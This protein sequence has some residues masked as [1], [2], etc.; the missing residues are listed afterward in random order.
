MD[1]KMYNRYFMYST[2]EEE[3][4]KKIHGNNVSF[5]TV[6]VRGIP[7]RYTSIVRD[8]KDAKADAIVV[9]SGDIRKIKYIPPEK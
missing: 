4:R 8:P 1:I 3:L 5:G 2:E 9:I 7:K 6:F